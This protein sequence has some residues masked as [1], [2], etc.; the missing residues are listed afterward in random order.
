MVNKMNINKI[1]ENMVKVSNDLIK[2]YKKDDEATKTV[3]RDF[4]NELIQL[5]ECFVGNRMEVL[6]F[7]KNKYPK[8]ILNATNL[9]SAADS[10]AVIMQANEGINDYLLLVNVFRSL[11]VGLDTLANAYWLRQSDLHIENGELLKTL[12]KKSN[13]AI[14]DKDLEE[15]MEV[16]SEIKSDDYFKNEMNKTLWSEIKELDEKYILKN[17]ENFEYLKELLIS[18]EHM[19]DDMVINLWAVLAIEFSYLDYLNNLIEG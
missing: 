19:A 2:N 14:F 13:Y 12:V 17:Q 11:L 16:S 1:W 9:M 3:V 5:S 15:K 4:A 6:N 18:T 10:V 7:I 8:F